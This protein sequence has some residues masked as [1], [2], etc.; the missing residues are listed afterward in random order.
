MDYSRFLTV[1][2]NLPEKLRREIVAVVEEKPYTWDAACL[3]MH[4][5]TSLGKMIYEQLVKMEIV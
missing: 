5:D 3:E 2:A 4:N 1:Y